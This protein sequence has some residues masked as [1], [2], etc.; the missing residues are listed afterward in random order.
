MN[1]WLGSLGTWLAY[2]LCTTPRAQHGASNT[3]RARAGLPAAG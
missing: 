2:Y 1:R 3:A